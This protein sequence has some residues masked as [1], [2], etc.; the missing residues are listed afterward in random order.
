MSAVSSE[1]RLGFLDRTF[2]N[3]RRVWS[4]LSGS[5]RS[6]LGS[7]PRP[8]LPDDDSE[9]IRRQLETSLAARGDEVAARARAAELG[10][11][12]LALN[13][14]GRA[15]FLAMIATHFG[16]D[17]KAVDRAIDEVR[18]A[19][20]RPARVAAEA[21]LRDALEPR[22]RR[23]LSRFT[24]L[25]EGMKFL[26]DIRSELLARGRSDVALKELGD[27]LR[28]MLAA[29]FD[30]GLLELRE[31][32]WRS[33]AALLEKLIAYEA[34]H[35]IRSWDDLK[36][37]LD[38]DRR[39]FAFFHP[40]M[41]NEPLIFV[42]VAL[43]GEMTAGIGELLD[44]SAPS[45]DPSEAVAAIFYSI[46]NAQPG[47]AGISFGNFLIKR[48]VDLLRHEFDSLKIF[49]TLSPIPGFRAWLDGRIEAD[50]ELLTSSE[51]QL[52]SSFSDADTDAAILTDLLSR[53]G[54]HEED[55][56]AEALRP[57]MLRL[58]ARYLVAEKR[59]DGRARDPVAHFHLSNG[60][61]M[62]RLNWLADT[63]RKGLAQAAGM[64]INYRY[65]LGDIEQNSEAYSSE[66]RIAQ[67][68]S[69][70]ALIRD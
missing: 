60:A 64:M 19:A 33:P 29:W 66:G 37:R 11:T 24:T 43:V 16:V 59:R 69:V 67:S 57:A 20:D 41:P 46:S 38:S 1:E 54:W 5:T 8:D 23:L 13:A 61:R 52:L 28:G 35:A 45:G 9:R 68:S 36:N 56:L 7:A 49:A 63:S 51:R 31:I 2:G 48:V 6:I 58:A 32:T 26:A 15:R 70:R 50:E 25:P 40:N 62:E 21:R 39:C 27:D 65:R 12:Y 22:W 18:G 10:R 34:V 17:R 4:D 14:D 53:E 30:I 3:L 44:E 42:E 55:E 47:L